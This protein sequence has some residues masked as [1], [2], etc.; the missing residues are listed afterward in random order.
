MIAVAVVLVLWSALAVLALRGG[1]GTDTAAWASI[2][3]GRGR[4]WAGLARPLSSTALVRRNIERNVM[5]EVLPMLNATG[6]YATSLEVFWSVQT[7]SFLASFSLGSVVFLTT[8]HW[9]WRVVLAL[10]A[11]ILAV[12]PYMQL[13][14]VYRER[15]AAVSAAL[16]DFAELLVLVLPTMGVKAALT[17]CAGH[18]DGPVAQEMQRLVQTLSARPSNEQAVFADAAE[19]LGAAEAH[20]FLSSLYTS[21]VENTKV[22]GVLAAQAEMMRRVQYQ[23]RRAEMKR[24]PTK[25]VFVFALHFMPLLFILA[26]LPVV[27]GLARGF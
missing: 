24:L 11:A 22:V 3:A 27:F 17:F 1:S 12:Y 7:L 26:F 20:T 13:R 10:T 15:V 5:P 6:R 19:R 25:L 2:E 4:M 14:S 23:R 8:L 16:P 18:S 21:Y 9:F